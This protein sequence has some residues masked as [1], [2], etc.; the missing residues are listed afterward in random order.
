MD[1]ADEDMA[2]FLGQA[3][4]LHVAGV[5]TEDEMA[6]VSARHGPRGAHL[7]PGR[8]PVVVG[9]DRDGDDRLVRMQGFDA[10][11]PDTGEPG[12]RRPPGAPRC[13]HR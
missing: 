1:D 13:A 5:F 8:R 10:M 11:S 4:Y 9:P 3:G 7:H 12:R 2:W 6:A